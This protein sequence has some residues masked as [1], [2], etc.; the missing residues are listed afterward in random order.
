MANY[1][2]RSE[3][4]CGESIFLTN[5]HA[6]VEETVARLGRGSSHFAAAEVGAGG[7]QVVVKAEPF[8]IG[9]L[10]A[11]IVISDRAGPTRMGARERRSRVLFLH[12]SGVSGER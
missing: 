8:G 7:G 2:S 3:P 5:E 10:D 6:P 11:D 1:L 9:T 12:I 4:I